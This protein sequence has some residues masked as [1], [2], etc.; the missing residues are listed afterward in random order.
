MILVPGLNDGHLPDVLDYLLARGVRDIHLRSVGKMGR[1]MEGEPYSLDGL[2]ACL[3]AA[4]GG[5]IDV[6]ALVREDGSSRDFRLGRVE[7]QLT[8]WPDL[9]SPDRGRIAPDGYVEPFFESIVE[10]AFHY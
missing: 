5:R 6:L 9:G 7:I 2:E 4:L 3:R 10:N 1:H 8:Q